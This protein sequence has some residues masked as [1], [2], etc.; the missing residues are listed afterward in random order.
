MITLLSELH[1]F[2]GLNMKPN[3]E[4]LARKYNC[5]YRTVKKYYKGRPKKRNKPSKLD[6]YF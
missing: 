6:I 4:E 5:D 2:R 3:F 1:L